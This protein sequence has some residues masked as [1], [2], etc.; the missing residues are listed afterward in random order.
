MKTPNQKILL[1]LA[2]CALLAGCATTSFPF[3]GSEPD[4]AGT[5]SPADSH[6]VAFPGRD[7]AF[8]AEMRAAEAP[9]NPEIIEGKS[10]PADQRALASAGYVNVGS[11]RFPVGDVDA[12][13]GALAHARTLGSDRVLIYRQHR[14]AASDAAPSEFLAL[15]YIRFR[16][17]FGASFRDLNASERSSL[18][19]AGGVRIGTV[20]RDSP[21]A[22]ANLM[23]NDIVLA[24]DG[25]PIS[26]RSDFQDTLRLRAGKQV[27]LTLRRN[28][29][30]LERGV[31]LGVLA[32]VD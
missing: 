27:N 28:E 7:A 1:S 17:P 29:A 9:P 12:E 26:G 20:V 10:Q 22:R 32:T 11:S 2:A 3:L 24:V 21:A 16:L 15:H 23:S 14:G 6:F 25:K 8:I 13:A 5:V 18:G 4:R 30:T 19:V 31:R